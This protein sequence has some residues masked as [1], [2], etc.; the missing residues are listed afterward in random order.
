[1][2]HT[3]PHRR[4]VDLD[5]LFHMQENWVADFVDA[6]MARKLNLRSIQISLYQD[7][8][9]FR[10]KEYNEVYSMREMALMMRL[11]WDHEINLSWRHPSYP[12][13]IRSWDTEE[14]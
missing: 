10:K 13:T 5:N 4:D 6:A 12:Y 8:F 1:M 14:N 2:E 9:L 7:R 3:Q 11:Y